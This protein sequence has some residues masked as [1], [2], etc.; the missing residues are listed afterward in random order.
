MFPPSLPGRWPLI[1]LACASLPAL[2]QTAAEQ[3]IVITA[4]RQ[5]TRADQAVAE[6]TVIDRGQIELAQG[7]TLGELLAQ[8]GGFQV[9]ANGGLGKTSAV[10]VRGLDARHLLL[11]VDGVRL[12]SA[13]SGAAAFDNL[14]L[15][16]IERIE[17]VRG[18]LSSLYGSDAV[19]GVVQVFTRRAGPGVKAQARA[20]V[21]S[22]DYRQLGAGVDIG[23]GGLRLSAHALHTRSAGFSATNERAPFGSH[24][25]DIDG[26]RQNAGSVGA[27]YRLDADW[28]VEARVLQSHGRT[29]YDDGPGADA[30]AALHH[31]VAA[32]ELQGRVSE[33]W[34][35]KLRLARSTDDYDTLASASPWTD[36]G[37]IATVQRQLSWENTLSTPVGSLLLLAEH[38][39]QTVS[40]PAS[41]FE[42]TER[43]IN[44]TAVGLDGHTG[45]HTWSGS[46]R[47]DRNSQFGGQ[48]TGTLGYGFAFDKAWRGSASVGSS[49]VAP[50]FNQL[51]WP[52]FSNP[53]LQPEEGR[54]A[55]LGLR[56]AESGHAVRITGYT[57]R[58]RNYITSGQRP[59][60]LPRTRTQGVTITAEGEAGPWRY[61]ASFDDVDARNRTA[62]SNHGKE[63]PRRAKQALRGTLGV[64]LGTWTVG[65]SFAA[66]SRRYDNAANTLALP[67]YGTVDLHAQWR[68]APGWQLMAKLNNVGD[69]QYETVYGYNQPGREAFLGVRYAMP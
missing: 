40:K 15:G 29:Q 14:P 69:K 26:F 44:A 57:N 2:A 64:D 50:S 68:L 8:Q 3:N 28:Q 53:L 65:G 38:L 42:R 47:H 59:D 1:A 27:G 17:I 66:F 23:A 32:A 43:T 60:N 7:R 37:V 22:N 13:T 9:A 30:R 19:G 67:G 56:Y 31:Q 49:F 63:L 39:Q 18:P 16:M 61:S 46:I 12:G 58:I 55:E 24:H 45:P 25:P 11:L 54:H 5:P 33:G 48:T 51:Y 34:R 20:T 62:G 21:G 10:F 41:Q 6:I 52:G 35:T 4:T 36:L